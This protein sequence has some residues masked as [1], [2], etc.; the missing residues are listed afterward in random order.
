MKVEEEEMEEGAEAEEERGYSP[1]D[2]R[3]SFFHDCLYFKSVE[4]LLGRM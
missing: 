1:P 3:R 2:V 4:V